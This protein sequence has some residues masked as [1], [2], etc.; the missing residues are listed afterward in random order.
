M[1]RSWGDHVGATLP[2]GGQNKGRNYE[3]S[4]FFRFG[5]SLDVPEDLTANT[6]LKIGE[7]GGDTGHDARRLEGRAV[8]QYDGVR[9][10]IY[11]IH[12]KKLS[13]EKIT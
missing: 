5:E 10:A 7:R 3:N 2:H 13:G 6:V 11:K 1:P 8:V 4:A 9:G 12:G